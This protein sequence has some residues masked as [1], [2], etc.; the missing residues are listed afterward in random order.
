MRCCVLLLVLLAPLASADDGITLV[1]LD[2]A[3]V[4]LHPAQGQM[5][6]LHFW[7]TWC[8]TCIEE[9]RHL[10]NAS[11]RCSEDRVRI[12]LVNVGED[13][14]VVQTFVRQHNVRLP[15]LRDTHERDPAS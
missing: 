11:T 13:D 6:V 4:E 7:A 3:A 8:P 12:L 14:E 10:Q 9:L 2:G 5:L 15:V 1:G